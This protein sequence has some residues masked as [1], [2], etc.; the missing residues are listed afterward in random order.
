MQCK[1]TTV[2]LAIAI[3]LL[4]A[5]VATPGLTYSLAETVHTVP[6]LSADDAASNRTEHVTALG[7]TLIVYTQGPK[8]RVYTMD[9]ETKVSADQ[10]AVQESAD[11]ALEYLKVVST[12]TGQALLLFKYQAD[13]VLHYWQWDGSAWATVEPLSVAIPGGNPAAVRSEIGCSI[14]NNFVY[15]IV[16]DQL[17]LVYL[18]GTGWTE[19]SYSFTDHTWA[20]A[21]TSAPVSVNSLYAH[22]HVIALAGLDNTQTNFF[23]QVW[24]A[25][26]AVRTVTIPLADLPDAYDE[27]FVTPVLFDDHMVVLGSKVSDDCVLESGYG[28]LFDSS[29]N[30][31]QAI[32]DSARMAISAVPLGDTEV[33][34]E[35][36]H[37]GRFK[38]RW[39]L[40]RWNGSELVH[41]P[42]RYQGKTLMPNDLA[43]LP[44]GTIFLTAIH[45]RYYLNDA[46][47]GYTM[48]LDASG[49]RSV[50]FIDRNI[51]LINILQ[52]FTDKPYVLFKYNTT[53]PGGWGD[54]VNR[55]IRGWHNGKLGP[56]R[57][58]GNLYYFYYTTENLASASGRY[59]ILP[60]YHYS[61]FSEFE[62]SVDTV[63]YL[64]LWDTQKHRHVGTIAQGHNV[65][66]TQTLSNWW[67]VITYNHQAGNDQRDKVH[68]YTL[69]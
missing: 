28:W 24:D 38:E 10:V 54:E 13:P 37:G 32:P 42:I 46:G 36:I 22:D 19:W 20:T 23:V 26:G 27:A 8:L 9:A 69:Q 49:V 67:Q 15:Q 63:K 25:T 7:D 21:I 65:A 51:S 59:A 41:W 62:D 16:A 30:Q 60:Y 61:E 31:L 35:I 47:K 66:I 58:L 11:I 52:T 45:Q 6:R 2:L 57:S 68:F 34:V 50:K 3:A 53:V 17:T 33:L 5:T 39:K 43:I 56:I 14:L 48:I 18:N 29:T 44:D 12:T 1:L 64:K 55:F 40:Y 4:G